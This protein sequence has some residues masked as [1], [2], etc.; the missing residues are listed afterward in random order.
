MA[1]RLQDDHSQKRAGF[2]RDATSCQ[3]ARAVLDVS[4][5]FIQ[6]AARRGRS[7]SSPPRASSTMGRASAFLNYRKYPCYICISVNDEVV[8]GL[9][10][11]R[12]VDF[13][14]IISLD[15]GVMLTGLLG[16]MRGRWRW[17]LQRGSTAVDG[18]YGTCSLRRDCAGAS[19]QLRGRYFAGDPDLR[20]VQWLQRGEG[21]CWA[22]GMR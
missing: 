15:V 19:R 6:R 22:R 3:V 12:R 5:D 7:T 8:H 14:D 17:R 1:G 2:G 16:I 9:A 18:C 4:S 10:N 20:P 11:E 21:V 13:G